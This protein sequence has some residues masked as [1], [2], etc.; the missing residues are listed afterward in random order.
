M[1]Q[2]MI[3]G[4]IPGTERQIGFYEFIIVIS[5]FASTYLTWLFFKERRSLQQLLIDSMLNR[6]I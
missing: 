6:T 2:F 4:Y 3:S 1:L 5:L